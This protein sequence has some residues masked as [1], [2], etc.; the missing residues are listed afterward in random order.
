MTLLLFQQRNS[1]KLFLTPCV[2]VNVVSSM[3][4]VLF[5]FFSIPLFSQVVSVSQ[6][7]WNSYLQ[8]AWLPCL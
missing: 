8:H 2:C 5:E 1:K 7:E 4:S 6:H 3:F